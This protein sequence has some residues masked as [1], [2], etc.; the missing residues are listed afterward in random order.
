[1][2]VRFRK[3]L[4]QL[5]LL[6]AKWG[7]FDVIVLERELFND[8]SSDFEAAF[9]ETTPR[10][11]L[12]VDDAIFMRYPEKF[13][14]VAGFSDL[15]IAGNGS[16][17][18]EAQR[19]CQKV[20]VVPTVIDLDRYPFKVDRQATRMA[21]LVI[22][23][24]G[25]RENLSSLELLRSPLER[26]ARR[27]DFEWHVVTNPEGVRDIP[28]F[29]GV[30]TRSIPW[31]ATSEIEVLQQ[32]DI[33]VMPLRDEPWARYKCGFKLIQYMAIG[34]AAVASPIGVNTEISDHGHA[35]LLATTPEE[36]ESQIE[37][38]L[39]SAKL[40]TDLTSRAR[41]RVAEHY[42]LQ[43]CFPAWQRAVLGEGQNS[44][45]GLVRER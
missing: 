16:L 21:P 27:H 43:A 37:R 24:T 25:S 11:V 5:D 1:M 33:G 3:W 31:S 17:A 45:C 40:R 30:T 29:A 39:S 34:A 9:R 19:Y 20:A 26:L 18:A 13:A 15:V 41:Q 23:W 38:L 44:G 2:S 22:G 12:D 6:R 28:Q 36:W 7:G 14:I 32:F 42:S 35:A 8:A 10:F 4:R